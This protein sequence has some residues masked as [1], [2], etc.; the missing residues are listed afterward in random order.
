MSSIEIRTLTSV[1]DMHDASELLGEIWGPPLSSPELMRALATHGN[2]VLGAFSDGKIVGAQFGFLYLTDSGPALHSHITGVLPGLQLGGIGYLL[3][4]A[5][6]DWC[7]ERNVCLIT[8]T[9]D[10]MIARNAYFNLRKLRCV[11]RVFQ[12]DFYGSMA[13][14]LN[15]G[16]RSDRLEVEWDLRTDRAATAAVFDPADHTFIVDEGGGALPYRGGR[17][18]GVHVPLD[19]VA[20][21]SSDPSVAQRWKDAVADA[22]EWA[23]DNRYVAVDFRDGA[24]LLTRDV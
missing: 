2:P 12:R 8:W 1:E 16:E 11:A 19:Y 15:Q 13:D 10:P 24:Y 9:F 6:R 23:F 22:F 7:L 14:E 17:T 21:K 18:V 5:Q 4:K 3:K 20:L